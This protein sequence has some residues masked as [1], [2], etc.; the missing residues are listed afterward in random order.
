M[1]TSLRDFKPTNIYV[2]KKQR[3]SG[4][5]VSSEYLLSTG[6]C[7]F[8]FLEYKVYF[9]EIVE[10]FDNSALTQLKGSKFL[11]GYYLK[12]LVVLVA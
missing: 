1:E 4:H 3:L 10:G 5:N 6:G 7:F 2:L 8:V 11:T 9:A 12:I